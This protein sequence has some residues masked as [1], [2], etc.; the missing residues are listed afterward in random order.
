A[1]LLAMGVCA[2][3][4]TG[5]SDDA[6]EQLLGMLISRRVEGVRSRLA[7]ERTARRSTLSDFTSNSPVMSTFLD[8][9]YRIVDTGTTLLLLG[10]TGVGKEY[11]ARAI[12]A[13]SR[14][15]RGPFVAINCGALPDTLLESELFGHEEGA[16][17]GATR[18]MRGQLE[19]AH[20][21]TIFLDEIAEMPLHLQTKLLQVLD[22]RQIR[23]LG[24]ERKIDIDVRIMAATNRN[25]ADEISKQRFRLDL[26]YRLSALTLNIPPLRERQE[27]I[28]DLVENY[29]RHFCLQSGKPFLSIAPEAMESCIRYAWPGNV[30]ELINVMERAVLLCRG[31]MITPID[32]PREISAGSPGP[33]PEFYENLLPAAT[34]PGEDLTGIPLRRA[35]RQM[36]AQL[37]REYLNELL[38]KSGGRVGDAA[39]R[40]GITAR[41]LYELMRR[42]GIR[43]ETYRNKH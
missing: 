7:L 37:E 22:T 21:G 10:E 12:H 30:R 36:V 19:L 5:I 42:H 8:V 17:T 32:L 33:A 9:V 34:G 4:Y 6:L 29:M 23:R 39:R 13:E 16:Y 18:A 11:L 43:K 15:S 1:R 3:V 40:A 41:S 27:D 24:S 35:R 25:L 2:V 38:Q 20:T 26:F 28:E 31:D 14:R